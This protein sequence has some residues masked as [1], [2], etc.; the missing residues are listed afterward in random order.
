MSF[1]D[2]CSLI[3]TWVTTPFVQ[4]LQFSFYSNRQKCVRVTKTRTSKLE[5]KLWSSLKPTLFHDQKSYPENLSFWY[6]FLQNSTQLMFLP[7]E[8]LY[9]TTVY[10]TKTLISSCLPEH[11][12]V[13]LSVWTACVSAGWAL[14][15]S[16]R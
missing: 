1:S 12:S 3:L 16:T 2:S 11:L 13:C 4:V 9:L 5:I 8:K 10:V 7:I 6:Y 14:S 15:C